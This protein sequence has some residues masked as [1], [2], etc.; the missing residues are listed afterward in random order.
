MNEW[1]PG[2]MNAGLNREQWKWTLR[3]WRCIAE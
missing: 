3:Q 1:G 2:M